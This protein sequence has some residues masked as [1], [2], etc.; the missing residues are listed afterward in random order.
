MKFKKNYVLAIDPGSSVIR[1]GVFSES[2]GQISLLTY[3]SIPVNLAEE[4]ESSKE[5]N[6]TIVSLALEKLLHQ[7]GINPKKVSKSIISIPGRQVGIKQISTVKLAEEELESSLLFE[8][9]K[10][11]PVKGDE[12]L[13]DYQILKEANDSLDVLLVVSARQ[14]IER[15]HRV[16]EHC[17]I[18]PDVIDAP[19]LSVNNAI[20]SSINE[21]DLSNVLV[22]HSGFSITHVSLYTADGLFMT[23]E[24]P[25]AGKDFTEEIRKDKQISFDEADAIKIKSG[26]LKIDEEQKSDADN[27]GLSLALASTG[28]NKAVESLTRELQRSIRFFIKEASVNSIDTVYLSGG[29]CCDKS[30]VEHLS[31]ELRLDVTLFDPFLANK[32]DTDLKEKER[33]CYSQIVGMGIR[34][35]KNAV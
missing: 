12:V 19:I 13:L 10:H 8:A 29:N 16:L 34:G 23:R 27:D 24:I 28:T 32:I 17:G 6:E 15:L 33:A 21:S 1:I 7:C 22:I 25:V 11:L 31:K 14:A 18:K 5:S 35:I 2:K 20:L 4:S 9:R 26:V 3:G 30:F